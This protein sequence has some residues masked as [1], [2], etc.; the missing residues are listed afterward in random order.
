MDCRCNAID[1][2]DASSEKQ[3]DGDDGG[4]VLL[5]AARRLLPC[6][7]C[8]LVAAQFA[9]ATYRAAR[10]PGDLCF[11]ATAY[12]MLAVL[13]YLVGRSESLA[14]D[15]SSAAAVAR[16]RLK[17]PVWALSAALTALFTSRVAPMMPPPLRAVVVAMALLV[18]VG[19]FFLLFLCDAGNAYDDDDDDADSD[20]DEEV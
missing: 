10:D 17:L 16:E 3:H 1:N 5:R 11:V 8:L 18:T 12:S 9:A 20:Q 4:G 2:G 19:G 13:L 14:A 6:V 15:G 7:A